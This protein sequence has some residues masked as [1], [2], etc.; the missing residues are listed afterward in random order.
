MSSSHS[1]SPICSSY[2]EDDLFKKFKLKHHLTVPPTNENYDHQDTSNSDEWTSKST[3]PEL[4]VEPHFQ[5]YYIQ[6]N[7]QLKFPQHLLTPDIDE[8]QKKEN[9]LLQSLATC[10]PQV[11]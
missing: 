10:H 3:T 5:N 6:Q 1:S 9:D 11:D 2:N 7:P 4:D 8:L